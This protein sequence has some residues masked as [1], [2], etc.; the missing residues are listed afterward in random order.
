MSFKQRFIGFS[1]LLLYL[2]QYELN[3][4]W[5]PL[6]SL[7]VNDWYKNS[8]GFLLFGLFLIQW[9][10]PVQRYFFDLK[11][12]EFDKKLKQHN[13][14]GLY[15]PII[16]YFHAIKPEYGFLLALAGLYLFN[17]L[18]GL[19]LEYSY[20]SK[21]RVLNLLLSLHIIGVSL[22]VVGV[23]LHIWLVFYYN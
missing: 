1:L 21:S 5:E 15:S 4:S 10:L 20:K 19:L 23:G 17:Q 8:T 2:I 9:M 12:A 6:E 14:I 11:E 7:Q 22:L 16:F 3:W 13:K 18:V